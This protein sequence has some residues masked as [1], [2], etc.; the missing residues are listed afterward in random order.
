MN[1][2]AA[3]RF[4]Q[5][6]K[7]LRENRKLT[8]RGLASDAGIDSGNLTRLEHGRMARPAPDTLAALAT[9]LHVPLAD[10]FAMVGYVVPYDLPSIT[11][12]LHA[13]YGQL[14]EGARTS[15]DNYLKQLINDYELDLNGPADFEDETSEP[16]QR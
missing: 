14:P 1:Q 12:Y 13:R 16:M 6:I 8:I 4:G 9:A 11:P 2:E 5:Y 10:M 3:Q 7:R 15:L